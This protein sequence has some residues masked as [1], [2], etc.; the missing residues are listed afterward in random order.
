M[1]GG[2]FFLLLNLPREEPEVRAAQWYGIFSATKGTCCV[3]PVIRVPVR[4]SLVLGFLRSGVALV[5]D[6]IYAT[7]RNHEHFGCCAPVAAEC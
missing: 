2:F 5:S 7:C 6:A 1:T 3:S 4:L